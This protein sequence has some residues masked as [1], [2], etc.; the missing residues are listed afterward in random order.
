M[1]TELPVWNLSVDEADWTSLHDYSYLDTEYGCTLTTDE[2]GVPSVYGACTVRSYGATSRNYDKKSLRI[3]FPEDSIHPGFTRKINL[4]AEYN[5]ATFMRTVAGY[6]TLRRLTPLPVPETRHLKLNVN[7][8]YYGLMVEVERLGGHYL[9]QWGR[10]RQA[11]LYKSEHASPYGALVPFPDA[12][13]YETWEG[14]AMF[15]KVT[16]DDDYSELAFLFE[17]ILWADYME[18]EDRASTSVERTVA[19]VD[20]RPFLESNA[21]MTLIQNRDHVASNFYLSHQPAADGERYWWEIYP[22]D[23]DI[24]FGCVF[25]E[26][27]INNICDDLISDNWSRNGEFGETEVGYPTE[28]WGNMLIHLLIRND[29]CEALY[30]Q[31][32]TDK[33]DSDWWK[34]R[35]PS[36]LEAMR[37]TISSAAV[38]DTNDLSGSASEFNQAVDD[39][40]AFLPARTDYLER[41]LYGNCQ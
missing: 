32:I 37:Q 26:V 40:E 22:Y 14:S 21:V 12:S 30:Y 35:L 16:G 8:S 39:M 36:F 19:N 15:D 20:V 24:S 38:E 33:M 1:P 9:E 4:R 23:V 10:D 5:D 27:E 29:A 6:E 25:D 18:G 2:G 28:I 7:G 17:D 34:N 13:M 41:C 11:S 31:E 3:E